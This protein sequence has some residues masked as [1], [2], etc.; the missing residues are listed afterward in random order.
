MVF[1]VNTG[2]VKLLPVAKAVPPVAAAY[3]VMVALGSV[4]VAV[5]VVTLLVQIVVP[6]VPAI[7]AVGSGDIVTV[8]GVRVA[9]GQ[10]LL[11]SASA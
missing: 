10:L 3:Q 8:T 2:V 9:D 5:I 1:A 11:L 4:L 6:P 7:G